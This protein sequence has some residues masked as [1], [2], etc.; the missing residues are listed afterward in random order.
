MPFSS[1]WSISIVVIGLVIGLVIGI[2]QRRKKREKKLKKEL[3][4][5]IYAWKNCE[6][7]SN[8]FKLQ[9]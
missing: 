6:V 2:L 3:C 4:R 9:I 7:N 8:N 5:N 1:A